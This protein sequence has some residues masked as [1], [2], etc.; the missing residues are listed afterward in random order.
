MPRSQKQVITIR[1]LDED[2]LPA[3]MDIEKCTSIKEVFKGFSDRNCLAVESLQFVYR[4]KIIP[5]DCSDTIRQL[6]INN[7]DEIHVKTVDIRISL[8]NYV[9]IQFQ[10]DG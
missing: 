9:R 3:N 7:D 2:G 5:A 1:I 8:K 10:W 6:G 4:D